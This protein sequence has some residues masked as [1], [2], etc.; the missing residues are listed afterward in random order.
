MTLDDKLRELTLSRPMGTDEFIAQIKQIFAD[1]GYVTPS[2]IDLRMDGEQWYARFEKELPKIRI[3]EMA[4]GGNYSELMRGTVLA[5]A[6]RASG[7]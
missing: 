7:L 1:A 4:V 3:A 5:A 2:V 6:K